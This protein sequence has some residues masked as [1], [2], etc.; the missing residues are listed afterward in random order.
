M[1][2]FIKNIEIENFKSIRHQTIDGCKRINVFIGYPN[3]GKSNIL[4]ALAVLSFLHGE[5]PPFSSLC[6]YNG[7]SELFYDGDIPQAAIIKFSEDYRYSFQYRT[8]ELLD[9]RLQHFE[10][11]LDS[12]QKEWTSLNHIVIVDGNTD[13]SDKYNANNIEIKLKKY[14]FKQL[15]NKS[16]TSGLTLNSPYG[17]NLFDIVEANS[18][19]RKEM[20]DL[21]ESYNL[22][23]LFDRNPY[24][25][26]VVKTLSD[27]TI[28][29][30]PFNLIAD[31]LQRLIFH[32]AAIMSNENTVLLFE[33]PEAHMFPPYISN[34]TN[35]VISDKNNNQYFITTHSPFILNDFM[36][37]ARKDLSIFAVGYKDG[38]TTIN[39][40]SEEDVHDIYQYGIDMFFNLENYLKDV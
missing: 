35:D 18:K 38:Q 20:L 17:E 29:S 8:E 32:K 21:L 6:R 39:R 36:E 31:T 24:N 9:L 27:G 34:F 26:K 22:K 1:S 23:L 4:E 3:V 11:F 14:Q 12:K 10:Q 5:R 25:L 15:F 28:F 2:D 30:I 33:E 7:V 19:L 37:D 16:K 40:I 13:K